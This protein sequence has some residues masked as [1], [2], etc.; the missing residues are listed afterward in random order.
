MAEIDGL[1]SEDFK[2]RKLPGLSFG[3]VVDGELAFYRGLGFANVEQK[4]PVDQDTVFRTGSITKTFTAMALLRLRDEGKLRLDDTAESYLKEFASVR[5]PTRD[6]P[7]ITLRHLLSHSSGLP[8]NGRY[9]SDQAQRD[10]AEDEVRNALQDLDLAFVPGTA[11]RYS[12]LGFSLLGLVVKQASGE[13][14]QQA[15]ENAVFKPLGLT[16]A[17]WSA[18]AVPATHLATGYRRD[19]D[20]FVEEPPWKLGASEADGGLF[21]SMKDLARYAAFQLSAYPPRDEED[22]AP[23]RRSTVRE[24][25]TLG[26]LISLQ[27]SRSKSEDKRD[28][29][30]DA[31]VWGVGLAWHGNATCDFDEI[32]HHDG[33][34]DGHTA[35]VTMLPRHGIALMAFTN[36]RHASPNTLIH[37]ALKA[38]AHQGIKPREPVVEPSSALKESLTPWLDVYHSWSE[39]R[40]LAMLTERHKLRVKS[41]SEK[42][43]LAGYF[44]L[45]GRC[46]KAELKHVHE[47]DRGVFKLTCERGTL[48]LSVQVDSNS[49]KID[50]FTG[51][52]FG[53][54]LPRHLLDGAAHIH[55]QLE[56]WN[57]RSFGKYF[58]AAFSEKSEKPW[59]E[60]MKR[61][62]QR[63][64]A[65]EPLSLDFRGNGFFTVR[66]E[67]GGDLLMRVHT[68]PKH[69]ERI[70][71]FNLKSRE[72]QTC[73]R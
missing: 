48:E 51:E 58:D 27:V 56:R 24:M 59:F 28:A 38:L 42:E 57:A 14:Y 50:G 30:V 60:S 37:N 21:L 3:M 12:N 23:L 62:H 15:M 65:P 8:R 35:I 1:L 7:K 45:H 22:R 33:S 31:N 16:S 20:G 17:A 66:C 32:V 53:V 2:G 36:Q 68:D 67:Q 40:Y 19:G 39:E 29:L 25:H 72:A 41:A 13:S 18:A 34:I 46:Q 70:D 9:D 73:P 69:P 63:C 64:R 26:R 55:E 44:R 61:I 5:Y 10:V 49:G 4:R 47:A 71:G 54:A 11:H 52:S 43:E 6:S